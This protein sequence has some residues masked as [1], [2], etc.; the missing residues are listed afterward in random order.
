MAD[1]VDPFDSSAPS[2]GIVDPFETTSTPPAQ[3]KSISDRLSYAWEHA[4]PGGPLWMAREAIH[5]MQGAVEG[6]KAAVA[7]QI[8]TEEEEYNRRAL[9]EAGPGQALRAAQFMVPGAPEGGLLAVP[10]IPAIP[11][12][13]PQSAL[14]ASERLGVPISRAAVSESPTIQSSAGALKEVP[15]VGTPL[16]KSAKQ[17]LE[18]LDTAARETAAQY[19]STSPVTA[20]ETA[21]AGIENW[22]TDSSKN[23]ADRIYGRVDDLVDPTFKR[24]LHATKDAAQSILNRRSNANIVDPSSAVREVE[25]AI[26]AP[27]G[28][29]YQGIKD[30]RT[31]F[32]DLTPQQ[33]IAKGIEPAEARQIY[34]ALTEDLRGTILDS[35]G[36]QALKTFDNAN[37]LYGQIA[38]RRASLAKI[39]GANADAAPE[40]VLDRLV[41]M[42]GSKGSADIS[43]LVEARRAMG[44]EA[45]DEVTSAVVNRMGRSSPDAEFS[46]DRFVTAWDNM[47]EAGKRLMFNSTNK[48]ELAKNVED[49]M[50]LSRSYKQLKQLGNPSGTG[51]VNAIMSAL[52]ALGGVIVGTTTLGLAAPLTMLG[53]ALGGRGLAYALSRPVAARQ[54][55]EWSRAYVDAV[56]IGT[57]QAIGRLGFASNQLRQTL[58]L[59]G[60]VPSAAEP[61]QDKGIGRGN[62]QEGQSDQRS[63]HG[64]RVYARGGKVAAEKA[65][66]P[67]HSLGMRVPKGGS[68]CANCHFLASP[69]TC[70]N[71]GFVEWNGSEELPA[72]KD[73]YCCDN[74]QKRIE[75]ARGGAVHNHNPS[76]AQKKAGNYSKT[77]RFFQGLDITLENLKGHWRL[78]I[79]KDGKRWSV[80]MPAHYGYIKRT[81]GADGDHVDCYIGPND[82]SDQVFVV[83]QKDAETDR[84]DEHKCLI[85]FNSEK[86]ALATYKAGFS[87]GKGADRLGHIRRMSM[88]E[89]R[90]WLDRGDTSK[91]IKHHEAALRLAY[92]AKKE[93][94]HEKLD[95][96]I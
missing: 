72:P 12:A 32:R 60:A 9:E 25:N 80:K 87:D 27:G 75:R 29:N 44:P 50:T 88:A 89:F 39:I 3:P 38:E 41:Q 79:G 85:G 53:S 6:A 26:T 17:T 43:R 35:G 46:G 4:T 71:E 5:G 1:I 90:K 67:D 82:K 77:H 93:H 7:P 40:R 86:E 21:R 64:G 59:T 33:M 73:E 91:P 94:G 8:G 51:R 61:N 49:I 54:I 96:S 95:S 58:G 19:G 70:G 23:I 68:M 48:P 66:P 57:P 13:V 28:M 42:A 52:G 30:L 10:K 20:G 2:G 81:E 84:F 62:N 22:I 31:Y 24:D 69:T 83:D 37:H 56:R 34:G 74:Y 92:Q 78:G 47:S 18:G 76:E 45:W 15:F 11:E 14:S 36:P 63:A 65:L 16:V 55:K